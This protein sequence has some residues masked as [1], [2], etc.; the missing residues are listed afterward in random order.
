M[1]SEGRG[2]RLLEEE[3][4]MGWSREGCGSQGT[5]R[6]PSLPQLGRFSVRSKERQGEVLNG[7]TH[8]RSLG[9]LSIL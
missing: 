9:G 1:T 8:V 4:L 7:Q 6:G 2:E 5:G 3:R